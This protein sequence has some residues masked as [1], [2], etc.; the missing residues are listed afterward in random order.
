MQRSAKH[1][2][3]AGMA[4]SC[5]PAVAP[6]CHLFLSTTC[7]VTC[8]LSLHWRRSPIDYP[9]RLHVRKEVTQ[10]ETADS[11][12]SH[13]ARL[14]GLGSRGWLLCGYRSCFVNGSC[15]RTAVHLEIIESIVRPP[16]SP[17]RYFSLH[18]FAVSPQHSGAPNMTEVVSYPV[19]LQ[20]FF[21]VSN[22]CDTAILYF[23]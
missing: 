22:N 9:A 19:L 17:R 4:C 12:R 7:L 10:K 23:K 13:K 2:S 8:S 15:V 20:N 5:H 11:E 16:G 18:H 6:H 14:L 1:R 21:V 3:Q